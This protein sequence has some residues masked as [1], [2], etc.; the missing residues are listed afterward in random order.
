MGASRWDDGS[1]HLRILSRLFS[2]SV[3]AAVSRPLYGS[4]ELRKRG[5]DN[6]R[7][8]RKIS[9]NLLKPLDKGSCR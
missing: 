4:A 8:Y 7:P 2:L 1:V 5:A 6:I 3:G 9:K